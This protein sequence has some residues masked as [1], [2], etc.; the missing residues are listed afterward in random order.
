MLENLDSR[1]TSIVNWWKTG[2][3]WTVKLLILGLPGSGKSSVA[4]IISMYARDGQ[5]STTHISDYDILYEMYQENTSGQF[6][7]ADFGGFD[8]LDLYVFDIALEKLEQKVNNHASVTQ[9][10][11]FLLIEFSRNDYQQAF[12]QFSE[13]FLKDAYFL[14]LSVDVETCKRRIYE[15]TTHPTTPDDHYVSEYIFEAYYNGDNGQC[16][17]SILEREYKL[18]KERLLVIDNNCSLEE[19]SNRIKPFIDNIIDLESARI[20]T[21]IG[22]NELFAGVQ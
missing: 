5:W 13:G 7:P 4:S 1:L 11:G 17:P 9:S 10:E 18:D 2:R 16:L 3:A 6:K 14:Y 22:Q 19:A 20:R 21:S 8:V 15:R 12:H